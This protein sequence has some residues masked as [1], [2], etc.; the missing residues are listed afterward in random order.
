MNWQ[1]KLHYKNNSWKHLIAYFDS[2]EVISYFL[3][4]YNFECIFIE[5]VLYFDHDLNVWQN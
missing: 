5:K 4:K 3:K 2:L 1:F